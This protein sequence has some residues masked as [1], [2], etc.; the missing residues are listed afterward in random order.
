MIKTYLVGG[1]VRDQLLNI[2]IK[3][4]DYVV[5]GSHPEAMIKQGFKPVGKDFPVF[6]HPKTH[7]EYALARTEKKVGRGYHGFEFYALPDVTL[8]EDLQRRDITINAIAQDEEGQFI[9]PFGGMDDVKHK[10]IR[11]VSDAFE[12]DP[13]RVLRVARFQA[14]LPEFSID[15]A[16]QK[17]LQKIVANDEIQSLSSERMIEEIKKGLAEKGAA[18]MFEVLN[19]CGALDVIMPDANYNEYQAYLEALCKLDAFQNIDLDDRLSLVLMLLYFDYGTFKNSL[20]KTIKKLKINS[21]QSNVINHIKKSFQDLI[22]IHDLNDES[23]F[24]LINQFDFFRRPEITYAVLDYVNLLSHALVLKNSGVGQFKQHLHLFEK[25]LKQQPSLND[26]SLQGKAL[27]DKIK[28][29]RF[30]LFKQA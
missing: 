16:T 28:Q 12:E 10:I 6:L 29:M 20:D 5:V 11:H 3:D 24:D 9:D 25:K 27:G 7:E 15:P 13:L 1:A 19:T 23:S 2:P 22:P 21:R 17:L 18:L 4:K 26:D 30:E 8:E 14:K